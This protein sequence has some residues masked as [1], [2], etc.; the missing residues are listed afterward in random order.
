MRGM[1]LE[2]R[3]T[4]LSRF[5][6][7][8]PTTARRRMDVGSFSH[9]RLAGRSFRPPGKLAASMCTV[10]QI[11]VCRSKPA[12]GCQESGPAPCVPSVQLLVPLPASELHMPGILDY[13]YVPL[14]LPG[15]VGGLV[16]ALC[17]RRSAGES[18]M[19]IATRAEDAHSN[20]VSPFLPSSYTCR[21]RANW[22][23]SRPTT[24]SRASTKRSCNP[25]VFTPCSQQVTDRHGT[26]TPQAPT[27]FPQNRD[28]IYPEQL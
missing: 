12:L 3:F 8:M 16:L 27:N 21:M 18:M 15:G 13:N 11:E 19:A 4:F 24:C 17:S 25:S 28:D 7:S 14:V 1:R 2:T 20:L 26:C 23:A 9:S 6:G 5:L 10:R 22:V